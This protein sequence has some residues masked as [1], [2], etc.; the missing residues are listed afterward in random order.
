MF[1]LLVGIAFFTGRWLATVEARRLMPQLPPEVMGNICIYG[2]I[3]GLLG[4]RLFHILEHPGEFVENPAA[5]IFSRGGFTIFGGLIVG[6]LFAGWYA[7]RKGAPLALS[8]DAAAPG[9][10][11]AYAI[12]RI[13]CQISGDGDWGIEVTSAAPAWLPDWLWAQTYE[14]N[15]AHVDIPPPGVY[16]TPIY[17]TLMSLVAFAI[18]WK[19][20]RHSHASGWLFGVY[21]LLAGI[22]RFAIEPIRVNSTYSLFGREVT[23][24]QIIAVSCIV[25]GIVVMWLRQKPRDSMSPATK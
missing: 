18:L 24:A 1:G 9:L 20:R 25:A 15:I 10:M 4:A 14:G 19:L 2:F 21:L 3:V 12:G 23:Q 11:L 8:L 6:L 17:E 7:R 22:E 5:M 16:P 13:G